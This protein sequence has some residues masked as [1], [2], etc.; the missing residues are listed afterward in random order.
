M[1]F[2][3]DTNAL[4]YSVK[5]KQDLDEKI[6]G[7]ILIPD[8]VI[9]ELQILSKKAKKGSDK[10]AAKLALQIIKHKKWE[11]IKLQKG[12]TD[13]QILEYA[14]KHNCKIYTFDKQLKK[15]ERNI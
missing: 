5:K 14:K 10:L 3:I 13:K 11:I 9:K 4:L 1:K 2:L 8:L 15:E 7:K 12:N 6:D